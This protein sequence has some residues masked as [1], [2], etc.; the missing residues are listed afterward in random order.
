MNLH[1]PI[2]EGG[3][4]YK[5]YEKRLEKLGITTFKDF[6]YHLP[7]RY[8]D[9]SLV[10]PIGQLQ[11]GEQVTIQGIVT[12]ITN[13]FTKSGKR[14]QKA[15]IT[16]TTGSISIIWFNQP[17]IAKT[18]AKGD[19]VSLAGRVGSFTNQLVL[20]SPEYELLPEGAQPLHTGR[21][22]PI[23]PETKGVSSK[24]LR[25]QAYKILQQS[26]QG[27]IEH[28]PSSIM[29]KY[30][31]L[32]IKETFEHIH[33]PSSLESAAKARERLA[34]DE[35]FLLQLAAK[36]RKK[37]W[38]QETKSHAFTI[39]SHEKAIDAFWNALPFEPTNAQQ[40]AI[41]EIIADITKP[42]PMNRLLEGDVGSGKTV[43]AAFGMYVA[44]INGFQSV[45]M[46]PTEILAQQHYKTINNLLSP[47]G[48]TVGLAIG[49]KKS[50][51]PNAQFSILIGTHAVLSKGIAFEK[52][53]FVVIDEQHRFG[54]EQRAIL[55]EKGKNPHVLT[56]TATPIPRTVALTLYGDLD[57]SYLDEMPKG[58]K[59]VKTWLVPQMKRD[60]A[61]DWIKK[62]LIGTDSQAFI[63]CPLIEESE[64]LQTVK[65]A[66]KEFERLQKDVY[67][68][69]KLGLLHGRLKAKE[70][71]IVLEQFKERA[72]DILV[73]TPVVEVGI[74]IPNATII[75]IEASDRFGLS[76]L[77]Q[78]RGRV[79]RG[80]KQSY[81]LLF[82][83]SSNMQTFNRLKSLESIYFGPELAELDLKLRGS[84]DI[85]GTKQHGFRELKIASFTDIPLIEKAKKEAL[86][87]F[88]HLDQY[89]LLQEK[90]AEIT[91]K[92]IAQN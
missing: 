43:V 80:D 88:P 81:C 53:G 47:L 70:K 76:Q 68:N 8:E 22:I 26:T 72:F 18:I 86:D 16:D 57:V 50:S 67:P 87:L 69:L 12:A 2:G 55:S 9:F 36:Q 39:A 5:S 51:V 20:E 34:F 73:A 49:S 35:L 42:E 10:S 37:Q 82:T 40:R 65:A 74:D 17:F 91:Q 58:R 84:G 90:I 59:R 75:V 15:T 21:L 56:M 4:L 25:R 78:L 30:D 38:K 46:A 23:Y 24:W 71:D 44:H 6:L 19:R 61:Y 63:I 11:E 13:S 48:V 7:S 92:R 66:A 89:P 1:T 62:E 77:H 83:E 52:L 41:H 79:G 28:L 32:P 45:L 54:V 14:L 33:F 3:K 29:D 85:Y 31:F 27:L 60:N 64:N